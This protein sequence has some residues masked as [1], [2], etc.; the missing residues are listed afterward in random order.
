VRAVP[1]EELLGQME[2]EAGTRRRAAAEALR[3][4]EPAAQDDRVY[5]LTTTEQVLERARA[6][7]GRAQRIIVSDLS[8]GPFTALR[9]ALESAAGRKITVAAKI[10]ESVESGTGPAARRLA[11]LDL[12]RATDP[13]VVF[14]AWPGQQLSL[15]V[16]AR[17]HLLGLLSHDLETVHQAVW[18]NSTFLSCMHHNHVAMEIEFTRQESGHRRRPVGS[19][20]LL[21]AR[22]PGLADLQGLF[23][24]PAVH[25][26]APSTRKSSP[27][28]GVR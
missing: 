11:R 2:R 6:M 5:S 18:S 20:F 12:V 13:S 10:Y 27:S 16:D 1:V 3:E 4:L 17:E 14:D 21:S 15:V 9:S 24:R 23:S 8:P 26:G 28:G 22:P 19:T 25:G 7:I